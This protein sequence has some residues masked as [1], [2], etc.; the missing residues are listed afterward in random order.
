MIIDIHAHSDPLL[1]VGSVALIR[2][3]CWRNGVGLVLLSSLGHWSHAANKKEIREANDEASA[4]AIQSDGLIRWLAYLNP[5]NDNWLC[6]MDRGLRNGAIGIKLWISLRDKDGGLTNTMAVIQAA[7]EKKIPVLIHTF[8]RTNHNLPGEITLDEVGML[9]RCFPHATLIAAHAGG[10][11]RL[12]LNL[13]RRFPRNA[14]VDISG[15]IPDQGML[16]AT[17]SAIGARQ[18]LFGSDI[19]GRSQASQLSKVLLADI[20]PHEKEAI[21]WKNA[22]RIFHLKALPQVCI[23]SPKVLISLPD[24]STDHFCFCGVW[25]FFNTLAPTPHILNELLA[26]TGIA[27]AYVGDLGSV[28][29]QD[30]AQ[31]N[32][33]FINASRK[34]DRVTPIPLLN[35]RNIDWEDTLTQLGSEIDG[36]ILYPYLHNWR[37][38]DPAYADCFKVLSEKRIPVWINIMFGDIRFI[39]SGLACRPVTNHELNSFGRTAPPNAYVIQGA[40]AGHIADF[41]KSRPAGNQFRFEISRLTDASGAL[42]N[43]LQKFGTSVFF[44]GSEFPLRDIRAVRWVAEREREIF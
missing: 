6:E 35:P 3:Q 11:W 42:V 9:A 28:Y 32:N 22:Q 8:Y 17:V 24:T 5:Q 37:L 19:L 31:A 34:A 14:F 12:C 38:D 7:A 2:E 1:G 18:I 26:K 27:R 36:V 10:H 40:S 43:F 25:P 15:C 41:L 16:E 20:K 30:I 39:H 4:C 29:R 23:P 13:L 33:E 21:L 44:M